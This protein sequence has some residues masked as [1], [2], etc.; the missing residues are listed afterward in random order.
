MPPWDRTALETHANWLQEAPRL[1][2]HPGQN[3][4]FILD[5]L[6]RIFHDDA[7]LGI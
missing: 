4:T 6:H 1:T 2:W 3:L 5:Y 7:Y